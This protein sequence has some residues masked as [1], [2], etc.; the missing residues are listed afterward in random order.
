MV[1]PFS[2]TP[3]EVPGALPQ[4][5]KA[6]IDAAARPISAIFFISSPILTH[7]SQSLQTL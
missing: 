3:F 2:E 1:F 7:K 5:A 6:I 4:A